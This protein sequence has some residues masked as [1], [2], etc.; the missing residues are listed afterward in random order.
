MKKILTTIVIFMLM[1]VINVH[2]ET[3]RIW[4]QCT[5]MNS[6]GFVITTENGDITATDGTGKGYGLLGVTGWYTIEDGVITAFEEIPEYG[7]EIGYL[8]KAAM[9]VFGDGVSVDIYTNEKLSFSLVN[10][11]KIDGT[12]YRL[13]NSAQA[14]AELLNN[15]RGFICYQTET[16]FDEATN[17]VLS[18][19]IKNI[20]FVNSKHTESNKRQDDFANLAY[21]I[22]ENTQFYFSSGNV[23]QAGELPTDKDYYYSF[24]VMSYDK[25]YNARVI[26]VNEIY[27][28]DVAFYLNS[29]QY[30]VY[31]GDEYCAL[32]V[33]DK[34]GTQTTLI[35]DNEA[36]VNELTDFY[37]II[38]YKTNA[39]GRVTELTKLASSA[40]FENIEVSKGKIGEYAID[41][42]I[43]FEVF[44]NGRVF[45]FEKASFS[46]KYVYS[47]TAYETSEGKTVLW[48]SSKSI[49]SGTPIVDFSARDYGDRLRVYADIDLNG[50]I[51][52]G[53]VYIAVYKANILVDVFS[54]DLT[55]SNGITADDDEIRETI[56]YGENETSRD[57]SIKGFVWNSNLSPILPSV[58]VIIK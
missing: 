19:K 43:A 20:M 18:V 35:L 17:E 31:D 42:I 37:G 30:V 13:N 9:D 2:A 7:F 32:K 34:A 23:Y 41:D 6:S 58:D 52:N 26:K 21:K 47:G 38:E 29:Y 51:G 14:V 56:Q 57:F 1:I 55:D 27:T 24:D 25:D 44:Y 40:G 36:L 46:D 15:N 8:S 50:Y 48:I 39:E 53:F 33:V 28:K 54:F 16:Y 5:A 10:N 45:N 22:T 4:G 11:I 3:Q 49:A 12:S